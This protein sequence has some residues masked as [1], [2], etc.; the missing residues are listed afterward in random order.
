MAKKSKKYAFVEDQCSCGMGLADQ[1][2]PKLA[3][4]KGACPQCGRPLE[5]VKEQI[6]PPTEPET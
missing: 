3:D 1:A 6:E 5:L 4:G 2:S